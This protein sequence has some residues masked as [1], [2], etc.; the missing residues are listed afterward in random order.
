M[1]KLSLKCSF[2]CKNPL[3][4]LD[5]KKK[6]GS[7][8]TDNYTMTVSLNSA[9]SVATLECSSCGY[10]SKI[11]VSDTPLYLNKINGQVIKLSE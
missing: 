9:N 6:M 5:T 10:K 11:D 4:F 8:T 2:K 7:I 3:H 1:N